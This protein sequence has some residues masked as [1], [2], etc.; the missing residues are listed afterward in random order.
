MLKSYVQLYSHGEIQIQTLTHGYQDCLD[1]DLFQS[2]ISKLVQFMVNVYF[3]ILIML[4]L[5][6][7]SND[8]EGTKV[9]KFAAACHPNSRIRCL[10]SSS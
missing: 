6:K 8:Q 5:S 4:Y 10:T 3:N 7:I 9:M 2:V 1:F